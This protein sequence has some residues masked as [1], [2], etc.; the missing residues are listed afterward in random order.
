M[1]FPVCFHR[2]ELWKRFSALI[3]G[4]VGSLRQIYHFQIWNKYFFFQIWN[5][6]FFFQIWNKY[7]FVKIWSKYLFRLKCFNYFWMKFIR[8]MFFNVNV[9]HWK[10]FEVVEIS[11]LLLWKEFFR[12]GSNMGA[13]L[14]FHCALY[15]TSSPLIA[16]FYPLHGIRKVSRISPFTFET[17]MKNYLNV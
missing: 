7:F 10:S 3:M 4:S 17:F 16:F 6:Y 12:K 15:C 13:S 14:W 1:C 8:H 9:C 11:N 5:K 2:W